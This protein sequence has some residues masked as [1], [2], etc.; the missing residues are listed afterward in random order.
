MHKKTDGLASFAKPT[1]S[2]IN[3]SM[4]DAMKINLPA[5]NFISVKGEVSTTANK[6]TY[7]RDC[8]FGGR[9][10]TVKTRAAFQKLGLYWTYSVIS[11]NLKLNARSSDIFNQFPHN[12]ILK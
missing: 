2:T 11:K 8:V 12:T 6:S 9:F 10:R 1:G 4:T 7:T 5:D 3:K